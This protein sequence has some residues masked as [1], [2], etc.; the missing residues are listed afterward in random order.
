MSAPAALVVSRSSALMTGLATSR[1]SIVPAHP[2]SSVNDWTVAARHERLDA[3]VI[4]TAADEAT[5]VLRALRSAGCLIPAL[6]V[7]M[8]SEQAAAVDPHGSVDGVV[9]PASIVAIVTSL[10]RLIARVGR[11][12]PPDEALPLPRDAGVGAEGVIRPAGEIPHV[13][14]LDAPGQAAPVAAV[15]A[16]ARRSPAHA[17]VVPSRRPS[18]VLTDPLAYD[19]HAVE[20]ARTLLTVTESL[21]S[22][23]GAAGLVLARAML[24]TAADAGAVMLS[25]GMEWRVAAGAGLRPLEWRLQLHESHWVVE[26]VARANRVVVVGDTD[27]VRGR[28]SPLPLSSAKHLMIAPLR[29]A[30]GVIVLTRAEAFGKDDV[31]RL[32]DLPSSVFEHIA[33]SLH[34]R[35]LARALDPLRDLP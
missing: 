18:H 26:N 7:G 5:R 1:F 33:D 19:R 11:T 17:S 23:S 14:Q 8:S 2:D 31:Q 10:E 12:A 4:A 15:A 21:P 22:T 35:A 29:R 30:P 3:L 27:S 16:S 24:V 34:V 25:D 13:V 32:D 9:L 28:L 20:L 6:V